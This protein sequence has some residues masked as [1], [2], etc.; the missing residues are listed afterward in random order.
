[1]TALQIVERDIIINT[2]S[3]SKL[4]TDL[5]SNRIIWEYVGR[6]PKV[7]Y[8]YIRVSLRYGGYTNITNTRETKSFWQ[9]SGICD[10]DTALAQNL[11][12]AIHDT[13]HSKYPIVP[14]RYSNEILLMYKILEE[15]SLFRSFKYH[16]E[17]IFD[18]GG[19]YCIQL[20]LCEVT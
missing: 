7:N 11:I 6:V 8:P 16:N 4:I 17:P 2:L 15:Q 5:V 12:N 9:V 10:D 13:L 1:M 14:D 19:L 3:E 18:V 20:A